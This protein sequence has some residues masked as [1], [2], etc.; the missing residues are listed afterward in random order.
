MK[1]FFFLE[2]R[3]LYLHYLLDVAVDPGLAHVVDLLLQELES[4]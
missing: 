4:R 1:R 2:N 3:L